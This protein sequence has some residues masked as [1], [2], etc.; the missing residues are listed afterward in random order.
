MVFTA[1]LSF[2]F[3]KYSFGSKT[4][5]RWLN[6]FETTAKALVR[7]VNPHRCF[8]LVWLIRPLLSMCVC[9]QTVLDWR[10]PH[11]AVSYV[12]PVGAGQPPPIL[13]LLVHAVWC[14]SLSIHAG[15]LSYSAEWKTSAEEV[16]V[17]V[18]DDAGGAQQN[19]VFYSGLHPLFS[20][21]SALVHTSL[22]ELAWNVFWI[23][24][25]LSSLCHR[26]RT[27]TCV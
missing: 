21:R 12:V 1:V 27:K 2:G 25:L 26:S 3:T 8:H 7:S 15:V 19:A 11:S 6:L 22:E 4:Y 24:H 10:L 9:V 17:V 20:V 14:W 5:F 13:F 16:E 18:P 23:P